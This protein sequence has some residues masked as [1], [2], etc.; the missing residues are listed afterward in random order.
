MKIASVEVGRVA[1]AGREKRVVTVRV[2]LDQPQESMRITVVVPE[3]EE[4]HENSAREYGLARAKD[5]A[6]KF[7][8]S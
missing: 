4:G 2:K 5:V 6:R 1:A 3:S 8:L 7:G